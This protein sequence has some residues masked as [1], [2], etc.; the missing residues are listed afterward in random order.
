MEKTRTKKNH[1]RYIT[2]HV[3]FFLAIAALVVL[4][5]RPLQRSLK[6][7]MNA[8]RD[9]VIAGAE[10]FLDLKIEYAS[11]GPS[12]FG[13]LDIKDF[14][15]M[16]G[17]KSET[18]VDTGASL[19]LLSVSRLR[20]SYS[21][22]SI[23]KGDAVPAIRGVYLD[24]PR[25]RMDARNMEKYADIA[26]KFRGGGGPVALSALLPTEAALRI[27]RGECAVFFG[28]GA[29]TD[30][31]SGAAS[32]R[33]LNFDARV[34]DDRIS[35]NGRWI[36]G[37]S[38][39]KLFG[40]TFSLAMAGRLSGEYDL[41]AGRG[42]LTVN[43]PSTI[44]EFFSMQAVNLAVFLDNDGFS[45]RK[46]PDQRAYDLSLDYAFTRGGV[47]A[48]FRADNFS[49]QELLTLSLSRQNYNRYLDF[50]V[51]GGA[52]F[53]TDGEGKPMYRVDLSGELGEAFFPGGLTYAARGEGA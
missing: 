52:S 38:L 21:F 47:F 28:E 26:A 32:L 31:V 29:D 34:S 18:G 49:P 40:E 39:D 17:P 3:L 25:V 12:L 24:W 43:I 44:G 30:G 48:E 5:P 16:D 35:L 19:P 14:R 20:V 23:V 46:M 41:A 11:A 33:G 51:S 8:L 6:D 50:S 15:V 1:F 13:V 53:E 27:R 9:S 37:M 22:I 45:V 4:V 7:R 2:A 42:E 36:A 10:A